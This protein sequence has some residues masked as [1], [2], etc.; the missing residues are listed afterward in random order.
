MAFGGAL[1]AAIPLAA[2]AATLLLVA[3]G[4]L[5]L[6]RWREVLRVSRTEA[7][8][9]GVT[10]LATLTIPWIAPCCWALGIPGG[11]PLSH[12][13]PGHP[14]AG[15]GSPYPRAPFHPADELG[16]PAQECPQLKLV[17]VE[18]SVFF[19]ACPM[20]A[21]SWTAFAAPSPGRSTPC[22]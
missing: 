20:S 14:P 2:I 15:A 21:I 8:V 7:L 16:Q 12:L 6:G 1:I 5:D 9:A 3:R 4:L 17:R 13:A 11:L 22:S 18:G 10:L 19:G